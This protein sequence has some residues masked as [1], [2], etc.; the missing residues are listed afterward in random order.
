MSDKNSTL[1]STIVADY[2]DIKNPRWAPGK[3]TITVDVRTVG[4]SIYMPYTADPRGKDFNDPSSTAIYELAVDGK[5]GVIA[6][7]PKAD[8]DLQEAVRKEKQLYKLRQLEDEANRICQPL[9][10]EKDLGIISDEDFARYKSWAIYRQ[11][12]R[13]VDL[14]AN[15]PT[16]PMKPE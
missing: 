2:A 3:T 10:E 1:E 12:L 14:S 9:T 4:S 16:W 7:V 8:L 6:D 15:E 5:F 11:S 13:K